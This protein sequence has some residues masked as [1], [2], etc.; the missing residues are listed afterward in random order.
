M[1]E[2]GQL[3]WPVSIHQKAR[4]CKY[5]VTW[6]NINIWSMSQRQWH[7]HRCCQMFRGQWWWHA[8]FWAAQKWSACSQC[9]RWFVFGSLATL[10]KAPV[11]LITNEVVKITY[12]RPCHTK[13][14]QQR[15][16]WQMDISNTT[17][18]DTH[19]FNPGSNNCLGTSQRLYFFLLS[20]FLE[21]NEN[22]ELT[23]APCKPSQTQKFKMCS[24]SNKIM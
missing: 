13:V 7:L 21:Y 8:I 5:C 16:Q 6:F 9:R 23:L 15:Q 12:C 19:I 20:S 3:F 24:N 17:C 14:I 18:I 10:C 11:S 1:Q 4:R 22:L 2:N